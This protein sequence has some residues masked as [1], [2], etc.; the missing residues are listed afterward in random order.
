MRPLSLKMKINNILL[1][2]AALIAGTVT[3]TGAAEEQLVDKAKEFTEFYANRL[4]KDKMTEQASDLERQ[5][6]LDQLQIDEETAK[7]LR[8][9]RNP[10][11]PQLPEEL[12]QSEPE[13]PD[14]EEA[15]TQPDEQTSTAETSDDISQQPPVVEE[16]VLPKPD[17]KIS[18]IVWNTDR[19]QAII[20]GRIVDIGDSIEQW[21][22]IAISRGG[23][24]IS[25]KNQRFLIEP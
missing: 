4:T 10:F 7:M 12:P 5:F 23:V 2:I 25:F 24:E 16:V 8:A 21:R 18:G 11:L 9:L 1:V 13:S 17:Y 15:G 6:H 14:G 20:E 19:P 22:I 3:T